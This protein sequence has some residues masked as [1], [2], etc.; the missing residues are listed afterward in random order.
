MHR[1]SRVPALAGASLHDAETAPH[2]HYLPGMGQQW[3]LPLYDPLT[4]WLGVRS[5]H[6]RLLGLAGV[7]AG[8]RV[9]EIGCG[10]GNLAVL[11]A[12]RCPTAQV[13]GI[14]PDP[15]ALARA[16]RKAHRAGAS[17]Q[18]DQG[19]AE[20]LPYEDGRFDHVLSALMFHHLPPDGRPAALREVAR[21]LRPGGALHLLDFGAGGGRPAGLTGRLMRHRPRLQDSFGDRLPTLMREAGLV[22]P[23]EVGQASTRVGRCAIY[24]ARAA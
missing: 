13:A 3:L 14:D 1:R 8:E 12:T 5:A 2:R 15:Q 17:V 18:L 6:R 20:Q 11:L 23:I 21:V 19:F 16:R 22:D 4:R 24:R 10:T 7:G 9:L